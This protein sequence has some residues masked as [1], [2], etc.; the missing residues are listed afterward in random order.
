MNRLSAWEAQFERRYP[1]TW[2]LVWIVVLAALGAEI[3]ALSLI[4]EAL[5]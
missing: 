3:V 2:G 4:A 5:L 1:I